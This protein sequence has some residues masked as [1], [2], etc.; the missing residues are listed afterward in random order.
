MHT[1]ALKRFEIETDQWIVW[2]LELANVKMLS[3]ES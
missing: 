1:D 2:N 3:I